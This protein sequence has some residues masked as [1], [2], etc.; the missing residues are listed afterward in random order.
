M[1]NNQHDFKVALDEIQNSAFRWAKPVEYDA[2]IFALRIADKL[3]Q[4]PSPAM[5][6]EGHGVYPE[7]YYTSEDENSTMG[8]VF[9][10]M[11]D[12]MLKELE[13]GNR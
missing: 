2:I 5:I 6:D 8:D 11:R 7:D 3:M 9:K 10:A 12:Q 4:E 13:D 1:T